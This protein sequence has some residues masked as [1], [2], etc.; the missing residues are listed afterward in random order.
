MRLLII[1]D[2][3]TGG[4]GNVAQQLASL[5]SENK[6]NVVYLMVE[7][8]SKPKYD[9]SRVNIINREIVPVKLHNPIKKIK[10]YIGN[11]K[12][13]RNTINGCSADI[14]I[15]FLN[16]I[17]PEVLLSQWCTKTPIIVSER[18]NPY[19][20]WGRKGWLFRIKWWLSY[21]RA[22][23]IVYQFKCFEPFFKFAFKRNKTCAIPNMIFDSAELQNHKEGNILYPIKFASVSTL[24]PVKRINLMI[25]MFAELKK[26]CPE[27]ELN[28]YGDGPDRVKLEGQVEQMG[29]HDCI[30][31]HG[32]V[33]DVTS[34]IAQN[35]ILLM[36]SEREGFPNV[37]IE[38]MNVG[39]PTV[40]FKYHNGISEIISDGNNGFLIEQDDKKAYIEKL[41]LLVKNPQ[42]IANMGEYG[43]SVCKKYNKDTVVQLW[44]ECIENV[45]HQLL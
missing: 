44:Q 28:I 7:E 32:H 35:D 43:L 40:T 27:I 18:S 31:F 17:S 39:V 13:L 2:K 23:K 25:E 38:A 36:T 19:F 5:F 4:A 45:V 3:L 20:E 24:Y 29:L 14:I 6:D 16:S 37:I 33:A 9:L 15:S 41:E 8:N 26:K 12:K 21:R 30:H 11:S 22:N 42:V 34:Y 1:A 10:R